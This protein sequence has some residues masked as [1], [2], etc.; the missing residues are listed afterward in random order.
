MSEMPSE[1]REQAVERTSALPEELPGTLTVERGWT[2]ASQN[3]VETVKEG[4]DR[5]QLTVSEVLNKR[6]KTEA[7][8]MEKKGS[9]EEP[10]AEQG[11]SEQSQRAESRKWSK[12]TRELT[13]REKE[14]SAKIIKE[15]KRKGKQENGGARFQTQGAS[16]CA[17]KEMG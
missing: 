13:R 11:C 10:E 14:K 6:T 12:V 7:Q 15:K 8:T 16:R 2:G 17:I 3:T 5:K 4:E 9:K 1:I